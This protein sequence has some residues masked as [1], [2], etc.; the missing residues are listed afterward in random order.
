MRWSLGADGRGATPGPAPRDPVL[1]ADARL[2]LE[3][4]L[5]RLA[6]DLR[7]DVRHDRGEVFLKASAAA[8]LFS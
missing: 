6:A 3:P 1:L 7:R 2:V 8:S 5:Y 4:D